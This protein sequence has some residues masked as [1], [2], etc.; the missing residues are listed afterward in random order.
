MEQNFK[1][2]PRRDLTDHIPSNFVLLLNS[3]VISH[4]LAVFS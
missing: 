4:Y 3:H 2:I 1:I